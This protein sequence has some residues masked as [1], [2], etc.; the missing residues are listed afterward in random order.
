MVVAITSFAFIVVVMA[1]VVP[2]LCV[3]YFSLVVS[4]LHVSIFYVVVVVV[5]YCS[6]VHSLLL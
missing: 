6:L 5:V 4:R 2:L 3:S 1:A